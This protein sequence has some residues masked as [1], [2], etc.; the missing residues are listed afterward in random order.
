MK[1]FW[2]YRAAS[3]VAAIAAVAVASGAANK[4]C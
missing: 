3:A 2:V 4:F 1:K